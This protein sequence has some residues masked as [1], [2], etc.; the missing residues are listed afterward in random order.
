MNIA[1]YQVPM[2]ETVMPWALL[3]LVIC[4]VRVMVG[5]LWNDKELDLKKMGY[6]AGSIGL[7]FFIVTSLG[8]ILTWVTGII[9][10]AMQIIEKINV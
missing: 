10:K 6:L 2:L 4:V 7:A 9:G 1:G 5:R 8:T 3:I